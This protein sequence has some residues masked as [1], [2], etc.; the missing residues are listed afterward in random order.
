M[1]HQSWIL[2]LDKINSEEIGHAGHKAFHLSVL[3]QHGFEVPPGICISTDAYEFFVLNNGIQPLLLAVLIDLTSNPQLVPK[4]AQEIQ[5]QFLTL[6]VPEELEKFLKE[7][8]ESFQ[9]GEYGLAVR[10]SATAEDLPAASFAG[11]QET[12]LGIK[13]EEEFQKAVVR[14]WASLW[15]ERSITYRLRHGLNPI[16][17]SIAIVLQTMLDPDYAGVIST[18]YPVSEGESEILI[19]AVPGLGEGLVEGNLSPDRYLMARRFPHKL[20]RETKEDHARAYRVAEEGGTRLEDS[21]K[22]SPISENVLT[23]LARDSMRIESIFK[24][25]V[26]IEYAIVS[27]KIYYLQARPITVVHDT[28]LKVFYGS[29]KIED[30]LQGK[31]TVWTDHKLRGLIP[32]PL[33]PLAWNFW[34]YEV[35]PTLIQ[36]MTGIYESN[37][38]FPYFHFLDRINGRLFW[39]LNLLLAGPVT[40]YLLRRRIEKSDH[41]PQDQLMPLLKSSEFH[42]IKV[43]P[44]WKYW[45]IRLDAY[46]KFFGIYLN[47]R[48]YFD[49]Q[50]GWN[51]LRKVSDLLESEKREPTGWNELEILNEVSRYVRTVVPELVDLMGW[52]VLGGLAFSN[53]RKI[54][55]S[56]TGIPAAHFLEGLEKDPSI[57][58]ALDLWQVALKARP[59]Q[60]LLPAIPDFDRDK[61]EE[62]LKKTEE[63][64]LFLNELNAFLERYEDGSARELDILA[65]RWK[66]DPSFV[67]QVIRNYCNH[68]PESPSPIQKYEESK[69]LRKETTDLGLKRVQEGFLNKVRFWRRSVFLVTLGVSQEQ[70]PFRSALEYNCVRILQYAR[71]MYLEIGERMKAKDLIQNRE[72][73]FYFSFPELKQILK[74]REE[75]EDLEEVI[76]RRKSEWQYYLP[77]T[78]PSVITNQDSGATKRKKVVV[79]R[80]LDGLGVSRG[81]GK[82]RARI[83]R[84]PW[85]HANLNPGEILVLPFVD[86]GWTPLLLTAG[87]LVVESG[88]ILG[89]GAIAARELGVPAVFRIANA[90]SA[91]RNGDQLLVDADNG[92]VRLL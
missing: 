20:I 84:E 14:C 88:D 59:I 67:V 9:M 6:P 50:Q 36:K 30:A 27:D 57:E 73:V 34:N 8:F 62:E 40:G 58:A 85:E 2:P 53:L 80:Q 56:W 18:S 47:W 70:M 64:T 72:D 78:P 60:H 49:T 52:I 61:F 1:E 26:D 86:P 68:D 31:L 43:H 11:Q 77:Q 82:G 7:V 42:P 13:T 79:K 17:A 71:K 10:S 22:I 74:G 83:L 89:Q 5:T 55:P 29:P 87:G 91:F 12:Y 24:R 15:S 21:A 19:E 81:R 65:P 33:A 45:K 3:L 4:V 69:R 46:M 23:Q 75:A 32:Y 25:P 41:G 92:T 66:E 51:E 76:L 35:F 54:S 39:N 16:S 28:R 48:K 63:G 38:L 44:K 37:E 90:T